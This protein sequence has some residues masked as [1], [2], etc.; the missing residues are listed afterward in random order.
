MRNKTDQAE[1]GVGMPADVAAIG[2]GVTICPHSSLTLGAGLCSR[3]CCFAEKG[4]IW[5]K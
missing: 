5:E 4:Q 2:Q 3:G 1:K